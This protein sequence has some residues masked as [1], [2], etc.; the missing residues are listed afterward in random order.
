M[1]ETLQAIVLGAIQGLTEFLPVSSSGHLIIFPVLFGW[2]DQGVV[3]DALVHFGTFFALIW[4]FRRDLLEL[5]QRVLKKDRA[6]IDFCLRV[7]A[8]TL[9]ALL[10]AYFFGDQIE[11]VARATWIVA[12]SLAVWGF[13]LLFADR[14]SSSRESRLDAYQQISWKQALIIGFAQPLALIPG[15]SRS[16]ITITAGLFSGLNR[17]AAAQF[18]FFLGIPVTGLAG[19]YG[20]IQSFKGSV[21]L[22]LGSHLAG[23]ISALVFGLFAIHVLIRYLKKNGY[24]VFVLYRVLLAILLLALVRL[25]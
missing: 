23:F 20:V 7:I 1:I 16:G 10:L 22:S 13:V 21:A 18:S 19:L 25:P 24:A 14:W 8:A 2:K 9:P 17:K 5:L 12:V 6:S 15:T 11:S 3:F 4:Y